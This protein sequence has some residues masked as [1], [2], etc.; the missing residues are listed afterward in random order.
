MLAIYKRELK[1]YF[2]TPIGYIFLSLF[3]LISGLLFTLGNI[4]NLSPN[5]APFLSSIL[6]IFLLAIPILTMRLMTDEQRFR[7]DQLLLTSPVSITSIVMGKYLA[8]VTMFLITI[9]VTV[10]YP[11]V[12]SFYG[13]IDGWESVGSYVGFIL[14]GCAFISIGLFVSAT[15]ENQVIAAI[16][17]FVALLI[18]WIMDFIQQGVPAD[19]VTSLIF[20]CAIVV[21]IGVWIYLATRN[22]I[23]PGVIVALGLG[24]ALLAFFLSRSFY[25]GFI[26]RVLE[27]L[28]LVKRYDSF[29]R[30]LLSFDAVVY[31]ISISALFVFLTVRLIEK[32]RWG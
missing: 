18:S 12:M 30:G 14:L 19:P 27:W 13:D 10:I 3:L 25:F 29:P 6:F 17:T 2:Q 23:I 21:G 11:I 20:L 15:T 16:V 7:T 5:Y 22:L 9:A 8:A 24:G 31:Y 32:K 28:S 1:T 4:F 26:S